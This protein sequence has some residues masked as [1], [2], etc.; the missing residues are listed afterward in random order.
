MSKERLR[1][2]ILGQGLKPAPAVRQGFS[3]LWMPAMA[4]AIAFTAMTFNR[5]GTGAGQPVV[6]A[7][8]TEATASKPVGLTQPRG[9]DTVVVN[10]REAPVIASSVDEVEDELQ[11]EVVRMEDIEAPRPR[12]TTRRSSAARPRTTVRRSEPRE[13]DFSAEALVQGDVP[14]AR[15]GSGR[16]PSREQDTPVARETSFD[17]T[18]PIVL[19]EPTEDLPGATQRAT[20]VGSASNVLV[21][22]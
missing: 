12:A 15:K 10:D 3:W 7:Q 14:P 4:C 13:A 11:W 16:A 9:V 19:I 2:A 17:D 6:V 20:E 8:N 21:G 5:P 22:G 18:A 1:D